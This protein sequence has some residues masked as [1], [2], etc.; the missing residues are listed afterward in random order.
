MPSSGRS[1]ANIRREFDAIELRTLEAR[2]RRLRPPRE[3]PMT[4]ALPLAT[5]ALIALAVWCCSTVRRV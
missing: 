1:T 4:L 3:H 2:A 5:C